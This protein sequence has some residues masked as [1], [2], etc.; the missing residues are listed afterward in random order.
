[1]LNNTHHITFKILCKVFG[2]DM[3]KCAASEEKCSYGAVGQA[4]DTTDDQEEGD[5]SVDNN[6]DGRDDLDS[7]DSANTDTKAE[8]V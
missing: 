1:M 2:R 8:E 5:E 7:N 3:F 4:L 6:V